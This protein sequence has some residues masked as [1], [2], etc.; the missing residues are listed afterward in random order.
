MNNEEI[1]VKVARKN[2]DICLMQTSK[3]FE[4]LN[5]YQMLTEIAPGKNRP[6]YLLG[7]LIAVNDA[8]IP[9][10]RLGEGEHK[11]LRGAFLEKPDRA[12]EDVP[13]V[14]VLRKYWTD[15]NAKLA[16]HF[17]KLTPGQWLERHAIVSEED[18]AKE[19]HRNRLA[20]LL[21]RTTHVGYHLGQLVLLSKQS[22]A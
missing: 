15:L 20:I 8:M 19:P 7:H 17:D 2:W 13:S 9:Q 16:E 22:E 21:S 4:S 14:Q 6:V 1:F 10:M 5:D 18:F 3:A 11:Q 12:V